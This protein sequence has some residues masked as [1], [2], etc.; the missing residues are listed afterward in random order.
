MSIFDLD[1]NGGIG[2]EEFE[3]L[4]NYIAQWRQMFTSFDADR[5]GKIDV[6]ELGQALAYYNLRVGPPILDMLMNKYGIAP[7][8]NQHL[9]FA[10][11][12]RVQMD[13]DHFVCACVVVRQMCDLHDRCTGGGS[14]APGQGQPQVSRDEFLEAVISLP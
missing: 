7:P 1:G 4:W 12:R 8:P 6:N 11:L 14:G 3:P 5:D 2:F 10:P 13:L 9:G